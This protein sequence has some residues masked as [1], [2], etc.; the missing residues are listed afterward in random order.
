VNGIFSTAGSG[1]R[2]VQLK[3]FQNRE[4]ER[5]K[6]VK[7]FSPAATKPFTQ[8]LCTDE[9]SGYENVDH[10]SSHDILRIITTQ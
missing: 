7:L 6:V 1:I 8:T 3:Y 9:R 2:S 10:I 5:K 4:G